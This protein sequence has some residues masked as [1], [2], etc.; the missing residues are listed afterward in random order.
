MQ[1]AFVDNER[2]SAAREM[3]ALCPGCSQPVISICGKQ[4]IWH[5][6]HRSKVNCDRWWESETE[7][8]RAWKNKFPLEW[9]ECI[10]HDTSGEKHIADVQTRHN[11]VI[12]FQHSFLDPQERAA[13]EHFYKNM[14]WVVSGT[15]LKGDYQRFRKGQFTRT[16][17]NGAFLAPH[18]DK[19]FPAAWLESTV[20]VFF[21]FKEIAAPDSPDATREL[22]W[23]LLPGRAAG[24]AVVIAISRP[25]FV[26]EASN[27]PTLL[28]AHEIVKNFARQIEGQRAAEMPRMPNQFLP[29]RRSRRF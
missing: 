20:P 22:L 7:W 15:R 12:E 23:C 17:Q 19:C 11:L 1:F 25:D 18:P 24:N 2:V 13:R 5:W 16:N 3:E 26:L 27:H 14:V 6:R 28:P 4:R 9:Q 21:D 10:Q 29:R 8:H